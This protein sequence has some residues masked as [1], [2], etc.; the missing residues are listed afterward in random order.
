MPTGFECKKLGHLRQ[1]CPLLKSAF[2]KRMKKALFGAWSDDEVSIS[3]DEEETPNIAN[4][5]LMGLEDEVSSLESQY[6]FT[7]DE[8]N[9][10]FHEL[11]SKF[12]KVG[13]R[14][15]TLKDLKEML[16]KENYKLSNKN[17]VLQ[18]ELN[19][20]SENYIELEKKKKVYIEVNRI[21]SIE[22]INLKK[23]VYIEELKPLID[24][25]TLSSN[26]LELLLK[27]QK[28]SSNKAGIGYNFLSKNKT[29]HTKFISSNA[30]TSISRAIGHI[31]KKTHHKPARTFVSKSAS[32]ADTFYTTK[33][34]Y[35]LNSKIICYACHKARHKVNKCNMIRR[36]SHV[37]L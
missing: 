26:K 17:K 14:I 28:D 5:C 3:S 18:N 25:L 2:K 11:M 27:D 15:K 20:S 30:S 36:N 34:T 1:D 23:K 37:K 7:F 13:S 22:N 24:K 19:A 21:L 4:L 10:T 31:P 32:H 35:V 6:E 8:L 12:K 33:H 29:S 16:Q 9:S